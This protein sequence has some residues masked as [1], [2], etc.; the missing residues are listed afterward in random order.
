MTTMAKSNFLRN[1]NSRE[2]DVWLCSRSLGFFGSR[3]RFANSTST[4]VDQDI[5]GQLSKNVF[6]GLIFNSSFKKKRVTS[7]TVGKVGK[8]FSWNIGKGSIGFQGKLN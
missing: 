5:C 1:M 8:L 4:S 2:F 3:T 7:L 6:Q